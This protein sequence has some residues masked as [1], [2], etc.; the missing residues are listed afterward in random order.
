MVGCHR[1]LHWLGALLTW[2]VAATVVAAPNAKL[3]QA[4]L[5][6]ALFSAPD[7]CAYAPCNAVFPE[8]NRFSQRKGNPPYVEAWRDEGGKKQLLGYIALSTDV[9]K[10]P[11]YSGKTL[12]S[13][14]GITRDGRFARVALLNHSEPILLLG[15]P[16]EK[17]IA[18]NEQ[19]T[20]KPIT[21]RIEIGKVED[22]S[23]NAI[24]IDGLSGA[25][26]TVVVQNQ[27]VRAVARAVGRQVGL[28]TQVERPE[29][30]FVTTGRRYS[31]Q[32]LEQLGLVHTL[33]VYPSDLGWETPAAQSG[34]N[35]AAGGPG[36][37]KTGEAPALEVRF[38]LLDHPDVGKSLLGEA[39][40]ESLKARLKPGENA[41]FVIRTAG[42]ESFK[43]S[44][45][46]RGGVFDRI[47]LR[48][49]GDVFT[50]RD[51]DYVPLYDLVAEG[52]P[53]FD[54]SGIFIVRDPAFS[55]AYP[56][57][58]VFLGNRIVDKLT[59]HRE[60][61][62]FGQS[63]WLPE[64]MLE[65]GRPELPK[66]EA[67]WMRFWKTR[68]AEIGLFVATLLAMAGVYAARDRLTARATRKRKW[69]VDGFKYAFWLIS[70]FF[71][72]WHLLA[73]PSI[74]QVLTWF[75]SLLTEWRWELFLTDP[76]IFLFWIFI[77]VTVF[78]W[79]RGL[80]C[81]WACPFGSLSELLF[82]V[83]QW[84]GLKRFQF[85]LPMRWHLRLKNL[86]YGIFLFL[87]A[88][89]AFSMPLAEKLA[90]VEPF[91]TTFLVG[92]L[93]RGGLFAAYAS[94]LL[95]LSLFMERPFCKYLCPLGAAL[96]LP[97]TFRWFGLR[98]KAE[99]T[100]CTACARGCGSLAI[101]AVGRID[102]R[103]CMLC[104]DCM[105]LYHD[106]HACPPLAAERKRREKLGLPLTPVG[107]D[108]YFIPIQS[109]AVKQEG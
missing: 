72:G 83:A 88:V 34:Q 16:E 109:V 103:E 41:I 107:K 25:T 13:L 97:T 50:F 90:E 81:G 63:Y 26:V 80:F 58:F 94:V 68:T 8:A 4:Q 21:T 78:V 49:L 95:G 52:T 23:G 37:T 30:R 74:T 67:S 39:G 62:S 53:A 40:W 33:R 38:G 5:P 48:Q 12:I 71:F 57:E 47:Q 55:A 20:G 56:W 73:Q 35:P 93:E 64:S 65:G 77:V 75:H 44:G 100:Q 10:I 91:K 106:P 51:L 29:A 99:C 85:Q 101:D 42:S 1:F 6:L 96:A 27:I 87:L 104:L 2:L 70:V 60:Y 14:I 43:G 11:A 18:F 36:D 61:V 19:Y 84:V 59:G 3:Y 9:T 24:G 54:E 92:I 28:I 82:K 69:P 89:S 17:L 22:E 15:I 102:H 98:R 7:L 45:F 66:P 32:E 108:G 79:G 105:V 46:V 76:F 86:K 31:W